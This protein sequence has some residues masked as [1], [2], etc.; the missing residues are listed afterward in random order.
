MANMPLEKDH[1][2]MVVRNLHGRLLQ[3]MIV[4]SLFNFKDLHE[5]RVQ[6]E[7]AIK[8]GIIVEGITISV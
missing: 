5:I 2:R 3:K 8:Q 6:I 1:V 7:D 4:L